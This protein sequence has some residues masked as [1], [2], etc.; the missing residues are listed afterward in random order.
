MDYDIIRMDHTRRRVEVACYIKKSSSYSRK[1][2]FSP[3]TES[4]FINIFLPKLKPI[5]VGVLYQPLNK[6]RFVDSLD[7]SLKESNISNIEERYL[8]DDFKVNL[9]SRNKILLDKQY[10]DSYRQA[11][12]LIK[13]YMDISF[14]HSIHQL[15][16]E[17]TR[18]TEHTK[19]LIDHILMNSAEKVIQSGGIE[20]GSSDHGLIHCS[21]KCHF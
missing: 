14:S 20:M 21:G 18:T 19:T 7:N 5:L 16:A 10:Y 9:L 13:K 8:M 11:P 12:P 6:P 17:P 1:S 3:N 15:T 2:S 4:I